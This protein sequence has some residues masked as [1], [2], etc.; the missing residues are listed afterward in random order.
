MQEVA[1]GAILIFNFALASISRQGMDELFFGE[2]KTSGSSSIVI[3]LIQ[4]VWLRYTAKKRI[5]FIL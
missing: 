3:R 2:L 1:F 4:Q 5:C